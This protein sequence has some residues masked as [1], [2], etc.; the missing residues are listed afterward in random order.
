MANMI[1]Y[2]HRTYL[3]STAIGAFEIIPEL[4]TSITEFI[5]NI[6]DNLSSAQPILTDQ[7]TN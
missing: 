4:R 6:Q 7:L 2:K 1:H 3:T 5:D